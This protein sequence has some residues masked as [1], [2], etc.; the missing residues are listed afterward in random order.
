M[1]APGNNKDLD[2]ENP[3]TRVAADKMSCFISTRFLTTFIFILAALGVA[4]GVAWSAVSPAAAAS[5]KTINVT[6]KQVAV[7]ATD[8]IDDYVEFGDGFCLDKDGED[9]PVVY[10]RLSSSS[11]PN[12]CAAKCECAQGIKGVKLRGFTYDERG[13][14]DS[15]RCHMD[16]LNRLKTKDQK[17]IAELNDKCDAAGS[18]GDYF[19]G[20]VAAVVF[21]ATNADDCQTDCI[22]CTRRVSGVE[23]IYY[24]FDNTNKLCQCEVEWLNPAT[25]QSVIDALTLT[26]SCGE[27]I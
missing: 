3:S 18:N 12:E 9:Y 14:T 24:E 20:A 27:E 10:F 2:E 13:R 21:S 25:E 8:P 7:V 15:C 19:D 17:K 4:G 16:W 11:D 5:S 6:S 1:T 22:Q 23:F 26:T